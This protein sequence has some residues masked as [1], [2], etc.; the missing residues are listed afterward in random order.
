[1]ALHAQDQCDLTQLL[2]HIHNWALTLYPGFQAAKLIIRLA[3]G[4][5]TVVQVPPQCQHLLPPTQLADKPLAGPG[6]RTILW[7]GTTYTF[8]PG[9]ARAVERLW[10][11]WEAG[12]PDVPDAELLEAAESEGQRLRDVFKNS[13]AWDTIIVPGAGKGLRRLAFDD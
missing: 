8:G 1:M 3:S 12:T 7:R 2:S 10:K 6:F 4:E 11:A 13:D 9:Q 5:E